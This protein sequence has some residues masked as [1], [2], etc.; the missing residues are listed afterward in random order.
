MKS[1][2]SL[3]KKSEN[4]LYKKS[5]DTFQKQSLCEEDE[6]TLWKRDGFGLVDVPLEAALTD[7]WPLTT[8][9]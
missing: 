1:K 2:N 3:Y 9:N 5:K 8:E 4:S 6:A 7:L